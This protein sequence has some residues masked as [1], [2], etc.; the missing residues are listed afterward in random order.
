MKL[1][2]R[3]ISRDALEHLRITACRRGSEGEAP[4]AVISSMGVTTRG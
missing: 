3:K 4:S 1:D 2:G